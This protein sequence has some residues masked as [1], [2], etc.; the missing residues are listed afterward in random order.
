MSPTA[1]SPPGIPAVPFVIVPLTCA[2]V[3][4]ASAATVSA[5]HTAAA[6][7]DRY[8]GQLAVIKAA[9]RDVAKYSASTTRVT[10]DQD[11]I[12]TYTARATAARA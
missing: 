4:P 10:R 7:Y 5:N 2:L 6:I 3:L 1:S 11:K 8:S 12:V 9:T